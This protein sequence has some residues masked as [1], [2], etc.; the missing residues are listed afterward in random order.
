MLHLRDTKF[1]RFS[2]AMRMPAKELASFAQ[3][4]EETQMGKLSL[5]WQ[6]AGFSLRAFTRG[7]G[8]S[9]EASPKRQQL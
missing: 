3:L 5:V 9:Q 4:C 2:Y 8:S 6:V 7:S 1:S